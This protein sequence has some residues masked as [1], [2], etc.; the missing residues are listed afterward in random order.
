M[1]VSGWKDTPCY[2]AR[3]DEE[4]KRNKGSWRGEW[5]LSPVESS[6]DV[7]VVQ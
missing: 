4:E 1:Q 6:G 7:W 2:G 3:W 5:E